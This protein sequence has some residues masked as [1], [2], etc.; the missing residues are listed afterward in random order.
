M[1]TEHALNRPIQV[2]IYAPIVGRGGVRRL[3]ERLLGTWMQQAD[4]ERWRFQV[5]SQPYDEIGK[6]I[7]WGAAHFIP[8]KAD[9]PLPTSTVDVFHYLR[10]NQ[11]DFLQQLKQHAEQTDVVWMPQPWWTLRVASEIIDL[12]AHLVP[13]VHDFAF[14]H[15]H[16]N[17]AF[18]DAYRHEVSVMV[19][20]CSKLVFS[21]Q[22][23]LEHAA[24]R[25]S[26]PHERGEVIYL[27]DFLPE[28]FMPTP[29]EAERVR[30]AHNLPASYFLA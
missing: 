1:E 8:L 12:P 15:L 29:T 2:M 7:D 10:R 19:K 9:A 30:A 6:P 18:G 4:P 28:T 22:Y 23:T 26:M 3:V 14:D 25:Y 16:W 13:T 20:A 11:D 17:D 21:S 5:L 27:G 24:S